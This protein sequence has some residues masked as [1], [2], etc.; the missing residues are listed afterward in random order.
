MPELKSAKIGRCEQCWGQAPTRE[1][2]ALDMCYR[3]WQAKTEAERSKEEAWMKENG[4]SDISELLGGMTMEEVER[5]WID[6]LYPA[7]RDAMRETVRKI[8][9]ELRR[10]LS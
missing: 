3:C 2:N 4:V 8:D 6:W 10:H 1:L 5:Q 9:D 7:D